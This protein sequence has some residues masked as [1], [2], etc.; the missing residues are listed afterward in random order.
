MVTFTGSL[1]LSLSYKY[2][3]SEHFWNKHPNL[4][5]VPGAEVPR[6][7]IDNI[8]YILILTLNN[9]SLLKG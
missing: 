1:S 7:I 2:L 9:L 3:L 8:D 4:K 6:V 5:S